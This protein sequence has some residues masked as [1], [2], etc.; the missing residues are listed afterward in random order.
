MTEQLFKD[1]EEIE[2]TEH[3]KILVCRNGCLDTLQADTFSA[4]IDDLLSAAASGRVDQTKAIMQR[5]VPEARLTLT[6][7]RNGQ[8]K[9]PTALSARK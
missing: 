3:E 7:R 5:L 2:R 1:D 4:S 9:Q 8:N 6:D